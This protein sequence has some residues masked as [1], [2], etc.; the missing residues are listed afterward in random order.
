MKCLWDF[1]KSFRKKEFLGE[2][3][4]SDEKK[5]MKDLEKKL[6]ESG[7]VPPPSKSMLEL[8]KE[9]GRE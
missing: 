1:W 3:L 5:S 6:E 8:K 4:T 7:G 2:T 9:G